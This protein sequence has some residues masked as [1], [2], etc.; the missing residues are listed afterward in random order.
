MASAVA[1]PSVLALNRVW[2]RRNQM[3]GLKT[4]EQS[5]VRII[6]ESAPKRVETST[7]RI[8]QILNELVEM[9]RAERASSSSDSDESTTH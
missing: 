3:P 8:E 4:P 7:D 9:D 5:I 2:G 6:D 1:L